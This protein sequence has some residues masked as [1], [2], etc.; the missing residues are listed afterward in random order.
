MGNRSKDRKHQCPLPPPVAHLQV[1]VFEPAK[2]LPDG[3]LDGSFDS[4]SFIGSYSSSTLEFCV[5]EVPGAGILELGLVIGGAG[6]GVLVRIRSDL[7]V[8]RGRGGESFACD[9]INVARSSHLGDFWEELWYRERG[10]WERKGRNRKNPD[11]QRRS[12]EG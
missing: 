1:L 8:G 4:V 12:Q 5:A 7:R 10:F 9:E 3:I 6:I 11:A 2:G